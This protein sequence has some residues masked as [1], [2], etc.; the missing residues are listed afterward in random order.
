MLSEED[1][2][3]EKRRIVCAVLA[4]ALLSLVVGWSSLLAATGDPVLINEVLASHTGTDDTEYI[5]FFGVAET[6]LDGLSLIVVESD[7]IASLGQI[8]R[9]LDFG[10]DDVLGANGFY[11]VGNHVGLEANYGITPNISVG[12]NYLENSSLTVA[13][14]ETSSIVGD[15]VTG[16]EVVLDAVALNDGDSGDTFFF[17]APVIGPDGDYFPAGARRAVDG[18]DTDTAEDW[19]ISDFDLGPDNTPTAGDGAAP[20]PPPPV[21]IYEIQYTTDPS[22]DSPY[23]GQT[24]TTQGVVTAFFYAGG[25]RYT[26]IQDG[27]GPWSGLVLYQPD[28]YVNVGDLL[29]VTGEVTEYYGLT[30]IAQGEVAF[31]GSSPLPAPQVLPT[32]EVSQEAWESVLL[33]VEGVTVADE[34]LGYG[35]WLVDDGSGGARVDDL[36]DYSYAPSNGD[37]LEVV[38]GP[39]FFSFDDFKIEPRDDGDIVLAPPLVPIC[40]IQ[41]DGFTSP[42]E[43]QLLRTRGVVFADTDE[44]GM[45]G[46]YIQD[47]DCDG[48]PSTSDGIFVYKG[49]RTDVVA[50][51]DLVEIQGTVQEYYELTELSTSLSNIQ[52]LSSGNQLPTPVELQPPLDNTASRTYLES[53]EG[54]YVA[55]ADAA[56]VGP[57]SSYDETWVVRSDLEIARVFQDDLEGTGEIVGADDGGLYEIVP[58]AKVGDQ[59]LGLLG[60][61]DYSYNAYKMQ[62]TA[63]PTIVPAPDPP[64]Y[65]DADGDGDVDIDD[66]RVI[67]EHLGQTVPPAPAGA[68]LNG[69]GRVTARDLLAFLRLWVMLELRRWQFTVATFNVENLFDT[70]DEPDKDDPVPSAGEYELQLDKLAEAIH[71]EL[72]EPTIIGVQ[73]AENLTVLQ[74]LATRPEIEAEYGAILVDGPDARGIDVGLLYRT[75]RVTMLDY[76]QRQGCTTLVDG[77]GP[78]GDRDVLDPHNEITCDSD[79][80]GILDGN[81]LFS[82][83]PLVAHLKIR[84]ADRI[85]GRGRAQEVWVI[86]NHLKS[87]SEDTPTVEYTLPRRREQATFVAGLVQE[88]LG[89]DPGADVIVLGDFNDFL[90]SEP[91]AILTSAGLSDLLLEVPKAQ[92]YTYVYEGESEVL[93]H[94]LISEDMWCEFVALSPV[95]INSDY[96]DAYSSIAD[97]ARRSSD[98]DPVLVRFRVGR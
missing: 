67:R 96:P 30:E 68:D 71:D 66:L 80:D 14:V 6:P 21:S 76:E 47:E 23:A 15:S 10:P 32:G 34:D 85:P 64:K 77:L 2:E 9:R 31:L 78:D 93:D 36:G 73:E 7:N 43:G 42:Y 97:T 29:E 84:L 52:I 40:E 51:G 22:G 44:T 16:D 90:D 56:V 75:D 98:H 27:T 91:L 62:L 24:V 37:L 60:G 82:R 48:D 63:E 41:G 38:Q 83:P 13:L 53:L 17:S 18:V 54:M 70:V 19:V 59:V 69:D 3:M 81:R 95:H 74:D 46:F 79:G 8:D 89:R 25:D 61:L 28:G 4:L 57:T 49:N 94:V 39:L 88:I 50:A 72:R 33:R 58:E 20:P 11:L 26:F 86:V 87:K 45:R 55:L 1:W 12:N 65:G 92:R 35:E 5:E